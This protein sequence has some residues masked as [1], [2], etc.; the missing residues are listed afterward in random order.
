MALLGPF[1]S[2]FLDSAFVV[3]NQFGTSSYWDV[4]RMRFFSNTLA[5]LTLVPFIVTWKQG[6]IASIR[7][8]PPKRY[9]EAALLAA[10]LLIVGLVSFGARDIVVN[11]TPALLYLPLPLLL[12]SAIRFW[13]E[14]LSA[15][16]LLVSLFAIW[17]AITGLGPFSTESPEVNALS[18][19]LFLIV[20]AVTLLFL[21]AV[22][23]ERDETSQRNRAILRANPDLVFLMSRHGVYLDY[24]TRR[25]P[26][27]LMRSRD[28]SR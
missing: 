10:G 15:S 12:W 17:G 20:A 16:L 19:Q 21:A 14:G 3:L 22:T 26:N 6:G 23:S 11:N 18:V 9:L 4:F 5:S 27:L 2:S 25:K 28:V 1:L 24:H 7:N 13:P 8:A